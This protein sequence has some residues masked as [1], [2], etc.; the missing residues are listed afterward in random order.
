MIWFKSA[1]PQDLSFLADYDI[2]GG[3]P[4]EPIKLPGLGRYGRYEFDKRLLLSRCDL[5]IAQ[6][7]ELIFLSQHFHK[8]DHFE[9]FDLS[10]EA[11]ER[12][13]KKA[14]FKFSKEFHPDVLQGKMLGDFQEAAQMVFEYG[15]YIYEILSQDESFR[16]IYARVVSQRD[17]AFRQRLEHER[18]Q[19]RTMQKA[20]P[21]THTSQIQSLSEEEVMA[22]QAR[23]ESLR[24]R[25]QQNQARHQAAME[26]KPNSVS[27]RPQTS[28][29]ST[30]AFE[31]Q[32]THVKD[33]AARFFQ[34]GIV[35][36]KRKQWVSARGHFKLAIQYAPNVP[37]YQAGLE[38]I[39]AVMEEQ[40]ADE[41]WTRALE[42]DE[43]ESK[44]GAK[45]KW[46]DRVAPLFEESLHLKLDPKRVVSFANLCTERGFFEKGIPWLTQASTLYPYDFD[47]KWA[48]IQAH[49]RATRY[50]EA[51]VLCQEIL[52]YDPAEPRAIA[53]IKKYG[54]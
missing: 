29:A 23:K 3:V 38:R 17:Q 10:F 53:F 50:D 5:T 15:A 24:A 28:H 7:R 6:K 40:K 13:L 32:P 21:Q 9:F 45:S 33:Q 54:T 37:E 25:L 22:S 18:E 19:Q 27:K 20:M 52:S 43:H 48:L 35:A 47:L 8:L 11:D 36:E 44:K 49:E 16:L 2:W 46:L 26:G 30:E 34:A 42:T 12:T 41:Q 4:H 39:R 51:R 31:G 14:Y 1:D